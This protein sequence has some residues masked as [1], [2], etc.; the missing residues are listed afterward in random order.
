[1][2]LTLPKPVA[3]QQNYDKSTAPFR[4]NQYHSKPH[5]PPD[6]LGTSAKSNPPNY[7]QQV[8]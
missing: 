7:N 5:T 2:S 6:K 1:M 4:Q 8:P 3:F